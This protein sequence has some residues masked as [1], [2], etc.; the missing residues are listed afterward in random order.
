MTTTVGRAGRVAVGHLKDV[1]VHLRWFDD[2]YWREQYEFIESKAK[3][4]IA[5]AGRR[6]AKTTAAATLAVKAFLAGKRV[7]YATPTILQVDRFWFEVKRALGDAANQGALYKNEQ[8][9]LIECPSTEQRIRA[10]TA[11]NADT[12][13]GDYADLLILDEWQ[14]MN[15]DAW[16]VVGAPML[17]DNDGDAVFIYTPPSLHSRSTSK[18]R[19]PRH[20]AKMYEMAT[21]DTTGTWSTH[22]WTSHENPVISRAALGRIT[23]DMTALAYRQEI[24]AEDIN[25]VAGALWTRE[26]LDRGRVDEAPD[27]EELTRIVVGVDPP[28]GATECGIIAAG[29]ALCDCKGKDKI[30]THAFVLADRSIRAAPDVWSKTVVD[31][32]NELEA[33]RIVGEKNYGGDMVGHTIRGAAQHMG[34]AISYKDVQ[35]TR[36]KAVRAEPIAAAY[37]RGRI[38]HVGQLPLLEEELVFWEPGGGGSSPNRL[39]ALV[40]ALTELIV[41]GGAGNVRFIG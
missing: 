33:D 26:L 22:H 30:E 11:W 38:H 13:R 17:L 36:G 35:A 28:G 16:G 6:G 31:L 37:E 23:S 3:R 40:W 5:R 2:V 29:T 39:D 41:T 24:E 8:L 25:E 10:K 1:E 34:D 18:A 15:E 12:L 20:A 21:Q 14:L 4:R 27:L 7:L 32:Y 19:D 9:H